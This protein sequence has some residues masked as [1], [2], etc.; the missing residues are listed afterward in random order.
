MGYNSTL[1][2]LNDAMDEIDRDPQGWWEK[3]KQHLSELHH[4]SKPIEFGHGSHGNGFYSVTNVH[5]DITSIIAVG[6]NHTTVLGQFHNGGRH[7]RPE[8]QLEI[9]KRLAD[10]MGYRLIR[11]TPSEG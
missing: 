3:A 8:D 6:G 1:M 7:Y 9:L 4:S 10:Q 5:A 2:I 11:K